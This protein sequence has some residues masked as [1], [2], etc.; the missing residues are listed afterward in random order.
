MQA[1][2]RG[3]NLNS[4]PQ[5]AHRTDHSDDYGNLDRYEDV[6]GQLCM[7]Q[8]YSHVL[9]FF[10]M[11]EGTTREEIVQDLSQAVAKVRKEVPWMGARIINE[12][13]GEGNSG[14][15]RAVA[16]PHP[17]QAIDVC[18]LDGK[19]SDYSEFR[20]LKAPQSITPTSLLIPVPAFPQRMEVNSEQNP[21]HVVRVQANIISGGVIVDFAIAHNIADAGGHF[22]L[23]KLVAAAMR[24][25]E[26]PKALLE[27]ANKDRR[28][29]LPLLRPEEPMLDHTRH[30]RPPLTA[31]APLAPPVPARY[32]VLRFSPASMAKIKAL[33]SDRDGFDKE[34][35]FISTD[36]AICAFIW[37]H[38]ITVRRGRH[39]P[40]TLSRFGRQI[41]GRKLVGLP[42]DYMG[43]MAHN[44]EATMTFQQLAEAPLSTIASHLR[45]CLNETNNLYHLRSFATFVSREP[46]KSTIT[47]AG[48]FKPGTDVGC[49][50]IRSL[51]GVFPSF[52][53]L[54]VPEFIRRPPGIPFPSTVV[55]FPGTPDGDCDAV[56]C[57]T[58]EDFEALRDCPEWSEHV[59]HI[60]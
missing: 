15:Y 52:G 51:A 60:G 56:A 54:G 35:P 41:D 29:I 7:L 10:P 42:P 25:E 34:V 1:K 30:Y 2:I 55:L 37:K 12:G 33:A 17:Q 4:D 32:H 48:D 21:A 46:D 31:T 18:F 38:L 39:P 27:A 5:V 28:D 26:F 3:D 40:G 53:K 43:E 23:V 24:G 50:S 59:E 45:K 58:D 36:D 22:G 57:L 44:M 16:C 49:S 9:Y 11:P 20:R 6:L 14:T 8:V 19:I 13:S 47:Y